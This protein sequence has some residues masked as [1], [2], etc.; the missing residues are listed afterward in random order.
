MD[1]R[2]SW[3]EARLAREQLHADWKRLHGIWAKL[4]ATEET[5]R[6]A[7][8]VCAES[9]ALLEQVR[10]IGPAQ[11]GARRFDVDQELVGGRRGAC[12]V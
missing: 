1:L 6:R 12:A 4:K 2:G 10:G 11:R 7:Q 8:R 3:A 9:Q 5:I